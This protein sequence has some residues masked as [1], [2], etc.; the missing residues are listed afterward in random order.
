MSRSRQK[1][2]YNEGW[3]RQIV[4]GLI[5]TLVALLAYSA[6]FFVEG[7]T[8]ISEE[9]VVLLKLILAL[10]AISFLGATFLGLLVFSA[11]RSAHPNPENLRMYDED[12]D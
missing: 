12:Y 6:L 1:F 10:I 11:R 5:V 9:F 4:L 3:L 7:S 2:V 8:L